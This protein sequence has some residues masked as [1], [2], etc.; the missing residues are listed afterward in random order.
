MEGTAV[1]DLNSYRGNFCNRCYNTSEHA[2][3]CDVCN[4]N[5]LRARCQ[6]ADWEFLRV[7]HREGWRNYKGVGDI[8]PAC[9]PLVQAERRL[10]TAARRKLR[11]ERLNQQ[12]ALECDEKRKAEQVAQGAIDRALQIDVARIRKDH[13]WALV[14]MLERD[15]NFGV[16]DGAGFDIDAWELPDD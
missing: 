6:G 8:C 13:N 5:S 10:Q 3:R 4:K 7:M 1:V 12:W 14:G 9:V 2:V 15:H 11:E 16:A